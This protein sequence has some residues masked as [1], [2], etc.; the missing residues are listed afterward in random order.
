VSTLQRDEV[1]S[2]IFETQC[3]TVH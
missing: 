2:Y 3:S 1:G